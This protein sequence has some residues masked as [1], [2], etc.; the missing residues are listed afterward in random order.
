MTEQRP[1]LL[2]W[3]PQCLAVRLALPCVRAMLTGWLCGWGTDVRPIF[4]ESK[5]GTALA[6]HNPEAVAPPQSQNGRHY[7]L[8][9]GLERDARFPIQTCIY[10]ANCLSPFRAGL[11]NRREWK[12]TVRRVSLGATAA[13]GPPCVSLQ[14]DTSPAHVAG[15]RSCSTRSGVCMFVGGWFPACGAKSSSFLGRSAWCETPTL[16]FTAD[17]TLAHD[18]TTLYLFPNCTYLTGLLWKENE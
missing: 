15:I 4:W 6:L 11:Q 14:R 3:S 2:S 7:G 10:M 1:V 5:N 16:Q 12:G 8:G 18:S 13:R 17:V 9:T